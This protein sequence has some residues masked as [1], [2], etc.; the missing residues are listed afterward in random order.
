MGWPSW[1]WWLLFIGLALCL[2]AVHAEEGSKEEGHQ[3][4]SASASASPSDD[5]SCASNI[6]TTSNN[7]YVSTNSYNGSS[8]LHNSSSLHHNGSTN[9]CCGTSCR[10]D[11]SS[12]KAA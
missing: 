7:S 10:N 11:V 9:I 2:A 3:T 8:S 1:A 5:Y 4:T 6:C 12:A